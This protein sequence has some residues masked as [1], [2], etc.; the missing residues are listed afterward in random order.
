MSNSAW[1]QRERSGAASF[2]AKRTIGSGSLGREDRTS[3]D[4]THPKL[5]IEIKLRAK[6]TVLSL[7]DKVA[8]LARREK[9][10]PAILLAEKNRPGFWLLVKLEDLEEISEEYQKA[11]QDSTEERNLTKDT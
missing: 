9:K 1:K 10:T 4:T 6:H 5:F 3:S 8:K 11:K 7:Y 2:G